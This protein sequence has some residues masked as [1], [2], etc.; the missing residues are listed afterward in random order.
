METEKS[1]T[2]NINGT[3]DINS[4][5]YEATPRG[6]ILCTTTTHQI[7]A[8][9]HTVI[10]VNGTNIKSNNIKNYHNHLFCPAP[11]PQLCANSRLI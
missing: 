2:A 7:M 1:L 5:P 3:V 11:P 9:Y 4:R 6:V 10:D 8:I